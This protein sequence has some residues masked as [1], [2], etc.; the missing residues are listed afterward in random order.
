MH[1]LEETF[2]W[3]KQ[4]KELH[5]QDGGMLSEVVQVTANQVQPGDI[6]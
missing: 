5:T 2:Q 4:E 3:H 1:I 6:L